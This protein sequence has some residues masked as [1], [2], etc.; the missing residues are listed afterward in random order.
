MKELSP[1]N[2]KEAYHTAVEIPV[3]GREECDLI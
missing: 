3:V 1:Q 2:E